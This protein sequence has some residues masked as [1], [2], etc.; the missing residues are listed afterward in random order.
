MLLS[1]G[2]YTLGEEIHMMGASPLATCFDLLTLRAQHNLLKWLFVP[3][4]QVA[5]KGEEQH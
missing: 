5:K 4:A 2:T 3:D 1:L